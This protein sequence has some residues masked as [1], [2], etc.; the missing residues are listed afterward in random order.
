MKILVILACMAIASITT[1]AQ[2]LPGNG[3]NSTELL[4]G[5]GLTY[6][7][8]KAYYLINAS[9]EFAFGDWGVGLDLNLRVAT[10]GSVRTEDWDEVYDIVRMFRYVRYAQKRSPL[11]FRIGQLDQSRIGRGLLMYRYKN[12]ISYDNR[13]VGVEFDMK[14]ESWGFESV[15]SNVLGAEIWGGRLY[16]NPFRET[17]IPFIQDVEVGASIITDLNEDGRKLRKS[18]FPAIY[19]N[20]YESTG[21]IT[22]VAADVG[23]PILDNSFMDLSVYTEV[24]S[25]L[26]YGAGANAGVET[27]LKGLGS[28]FSL[29]A[30]FESRFNGDKF[31]PGYF[32]PFYELER[33]S[34]INDSTLSTKIQT[35]EDVRSPGP[36]LYGELVATLLGTIKI[37]GS[38]EELLDQ[39][40]SGIL[41]LGTDLGDILPSVLF[42]A[43]YYKKGIAAGSSIFTLD[44]RSI[45]S[46]ELGYKPNSF[47]IVSIFY[48]WTFEPVRDGDTV[49]DYTSVSRVE[50]KVTFS[51]KF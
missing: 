23:L 8:G 26:G 12:S 51:F 11:Y 44:D 20:N 1:F 35:L 41:H 15:A 33:V 10:D 42:R 31:T 28:F 43:D 34:S 17:G 4:G 49:V 5:F 30:K 50:P 7:D 48:Q 18:D 29:S 46:A 3:G 37:M 38:Y 16:I 2:S 27:N 6:I 45:A 47:M 22:G 24:G 32:G 25:I 39:P 13:K 21:P 36:G 14:F 19:R 40:A 9:P